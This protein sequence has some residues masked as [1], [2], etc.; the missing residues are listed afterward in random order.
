MAFDECQ[1]RQ[2]A[3]ELLVDRSHGADDIHFHIAP[4]KGDPEP[5]T[6]DIQRVMDLLST[7]RVDISWGD[8]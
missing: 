2:Y 5:S 8:E 3:M 6:V 7:A 1:L 4:F